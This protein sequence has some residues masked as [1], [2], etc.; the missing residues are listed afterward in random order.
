MVY[1][2]GDC[3]GTFERFSVKSFPAQRA[4]TRENFVIVCGDFGGVWEDRPRERYWLDWLAQKPFTLL[5]VDGNHENFD[6]LYGHF[7]GAEGGRSVP[8]CPGAP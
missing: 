1:I 8:V 4:M 3:H 7:G 6:R 5:F 2:T